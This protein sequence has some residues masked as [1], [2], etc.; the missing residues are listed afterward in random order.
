MARLYADED[1]PHPTVE[2]LRQMGYDVLT[3]FESEQA[4]QSVPDSDILAFATTRG[5]AI[6][7]LNRRHF[8]GLHRTNPAHAGII[9]C[10][11]DLN[12]AALAERIN[13]VIQSA[14]DLENQLFRVNRPAQEDL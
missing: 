12:F 14:P 13:A 5:R 1:F 6:L 9:V 11:H 4:N 3:V 10:S 2:A 7:T 8:I